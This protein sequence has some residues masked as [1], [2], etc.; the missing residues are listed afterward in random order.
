AF[1]K[2]LEEPNERTVILLVTDKPGRLPAT[3]RSRCQ[4]LTVDKPDKTML[5]NWLSQQQI[6]EQQELLF[7]L[8][9]G[10]PLLAQQYA[11]EQTLQTRNACLHDFLSI[12]KQQSHP[13]IVAESWHKLPD[14]A[15]LFWLT[16]WLIDIIKCA[17]HAKAENLFNPDAYKAL[18][19]LASKL[20]LAHLYALYDLLLL[21][22]QR[23]DTQINKQSLFEEI[24]IQWAELNRSN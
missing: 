4:K 5:C 20:N 6:S 9:Q 22:R 15:L 2:C 3:I 19:E 11:H 1:L 21:S 16:S 12:A 7:N 8:A 18:K 17:Y 24:L 14:A 13:V 10:A 23:I